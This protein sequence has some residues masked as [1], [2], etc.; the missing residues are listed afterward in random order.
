MRQTG[1]K[2]GTDRVQTGIYR[3]Q[4]AIDRTEMQVLTGD[5]DRKKSMGKID[6]QIGME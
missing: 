3:G 1:D 6:K 4:T 5:R 2:Q